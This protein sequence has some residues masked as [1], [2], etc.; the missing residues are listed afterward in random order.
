MFGWWKTSAEP[1]RDDGPS[2]DSIGML[3]SKMPVRSSAEVHPSSAKFAHLQLKNQTKRNQRS[4][5]LGTT[6][7][8]TESTTAPT[9]E[10]ASAEELVEAE[11]GRLLELNWK[12]VS[13][14]PSQN[15]ERDVVR[16]WCANAPPARRQPTARDHAI[17]LFQLLQRQP[18][19]VGKWILATDLENVI[20]P[21]FL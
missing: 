6:E 8:A 1:P 3:N 17:E 4:P 12:W 21:H 16:V 2:E 15:I 14:R 18:R 5:I 20:Y 10:C 13:P 11:I 9:T 7:P 19:F